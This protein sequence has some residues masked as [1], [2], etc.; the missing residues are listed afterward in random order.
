M[1]EKGQDWVLT[2]RNVFLSREGPQF[3]LPRLR[4]CMKDMM[5]HLKETLWV[6]TDE[7][8]H[9]RDKEKKEGKER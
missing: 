6:S 8:I 9:S 2:T 7:E 4:S 5:G 3:H 1:N